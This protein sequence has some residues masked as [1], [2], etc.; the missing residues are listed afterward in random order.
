[1]KTYPNRVVRFSI[2]LAGFWLAASA[3]SM[4]GAPEETLHQVAERLATSTGGAREAAVQQL[5][6]AGLPAVP[7]VANLIPAKE[8]GA[9]D[10]AV[11]VLQKIGVEASI[12]YCI[13][14]L[15]S[16]D[17][18]VRYR[19]ANA[20]SMLTNRH[21]GYSPQDSAAKRAEIIA[22]WNKWFIEWQAAEQGR[23][24]PPH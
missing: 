15:N 9:S 19:A 17:E 10:A 2:S 13:N 4:L 18:Q 14:S 22:R 8:T 24:K 5:M 11:R 1:M 6:H 23:Q 7:F 21:F 16:P 12:A 20:L 3:S